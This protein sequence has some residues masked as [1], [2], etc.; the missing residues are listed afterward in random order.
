MEEDKE[1]LEEDDGVNQ[2]EYEEEH[3]KDNTEDND[4]EDQYGQDGCGPFKT[5]CDTGSDV[6]SDMYPLACWR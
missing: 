2:V 1:E 3:K 5:G 4:E 6:D